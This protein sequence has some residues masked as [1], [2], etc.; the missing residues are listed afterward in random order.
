M[1]MTPTEFKKK[2]VVILKFGPATSIDGLR[3]AEYY[4]VTIDPV[5]VSASGEFIRF[6]RNNGDEIQG[7]QRCAALTVVEIIGEWDETLTWEKQEFSLGYGPAILAV[8]SE[9]L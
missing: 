5:M 9:E 4:Q 2:T 1:I 6:G 7:W 3:P 8:A